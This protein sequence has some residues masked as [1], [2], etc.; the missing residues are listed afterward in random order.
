MFLRTHKKKNRAGISVTLTSSAPLAELTGSLFLRQLQDVSYTPGSCCRTSDSPESFRD[1]VVKI[2]PD[3][4]EDSTEFRFVASS[5]ARNSPLNYCASIRWGNIGFG[6][7]ANIMK[8]PWS[9]KRQKQNGESNTKGWRLISSPGSEH[10][11]ILPACL[12]SL[13]LGLFPNQSKLALLLEFHL[14]AIH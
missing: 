13:F 12:S 5:H 10:P 3:L 9:K 4:K 6:F 11:D 1:Q 14:N 7:L 8:Q 2:D